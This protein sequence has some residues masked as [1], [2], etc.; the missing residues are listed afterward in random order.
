M[1]IELK[2]NI[3]TIKA[4]RNQDKE[5]IVD[6]SINTENNES[7]IKV[8]RELKKIDSVYEVKRSR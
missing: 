5:I 4:Q 8:I 3:L 2:I 1:T 6:V 7:L